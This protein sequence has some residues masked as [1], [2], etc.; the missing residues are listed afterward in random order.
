MWYYGPTLKVAFAAVAS[1]SLKI[2][3]TPNSLTDKREKCENQRNGETGVID[4]TITKA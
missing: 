4:R 3:Q 1:I 2:K